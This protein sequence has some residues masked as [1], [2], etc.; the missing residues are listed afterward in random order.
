MTT[1][2]NDGPA[3]SPQEGA[4]I[5]Q[6]GDGLVLRRGRVEDTEA[7]A[8]FTAM[9][10]GPEAPDEGIRHWT[11]DLMKG[12][13]PG[14][15]PQDFTI[16]EDSR[17]GAIAATMNLISQT[18]SYEVVEF[19]VGRIELV[20]TDPDY[21]LRGL[22]RATSDRRWKWST[23]IGGAGCWMGETRASQI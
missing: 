13:P 6:L 7:L 11:R 4:V 18:W 8:D 15:G 16:V 12:D 14:F 20:G 9:H 19:A 1:T 10:V 23:S 17:T 5:R 3:R 2:A 22:M 21:R